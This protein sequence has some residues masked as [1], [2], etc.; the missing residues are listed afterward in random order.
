MPGI[1]KTRLPPGQAF[2]AAAGPARGL[3]QPPGAAPRALGHVRRA[4]GADLSPWIAHYWAVAWD[5]PPGQVEVARVASHP[6]VHVAC[7][8][9]AVQVH[10]V[11]TAAF[12]RRLEGCGLTLG[13][14]FRAG[15][16]RGLLGRPVATLRDRT[17]EAAVLL[18]AAATRRFAREVA[19]ARSEDAL[20]SAA[21][22]FVRALPLRR[23]P[24]ADLAACLVAQAEADVEVRSVETLARG[25]GLSVRAV[26][27]LF[28][29]Y[30]GTTPK[31]VIRRYRMHALIGRMNSGTGVDWAAAALDLG[32]FDQ[33]HLIRDFRTV[34]GCAPADYLRRR[35]ARDGDQVTMP[36]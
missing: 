11:H 33:S 31:W 32:Y 27:R 20:V 35:V 18:D 24:D 14:K 4:P 1:G 17:V 16:F 29:E 10:G 25:A 34:F 2:D 7:D 28:R 9:A 22:A 21:E 5:L 15:G 30:V 8:G 26:Q 36:T 12:E 13:V 23:D 19:S 3:L 6:N